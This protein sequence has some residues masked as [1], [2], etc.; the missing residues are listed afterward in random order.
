MVMIT[1][2]IW[3]VRKCVSSLPPPIQPHLEDASVKN[4]Q[5]WTKY[6]HQTLHL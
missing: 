2:M 5:A 3:F 1:M 4:L 6:I